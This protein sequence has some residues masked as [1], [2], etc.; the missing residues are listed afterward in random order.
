LAG[1]LVEQLN[2]SRCDII[3]TRFALLEMRSAPRQSVGFF[4]ALIRI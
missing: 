2:L 1:C 3:E 4:W